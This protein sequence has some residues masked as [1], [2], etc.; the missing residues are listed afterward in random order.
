MKKKRYNRLVAVVLLIVTVISLLGGAGVFA[1]EVLENP[2]Q[3]ESKDTP[4]DDID[5]TQDSEDSNTSNQEETSPQETNN[6]DIKEEGQ[7]ENK[8]EDTTVSSTPE[9]EEPEE[10]E[11]PKDE[12]K[13]EESSS[14]EYSL[15]LSV[16]SE[17]GGS[18]YVVLN[19]KREFATHGV[20]LNLPV[21]NGEEV[22]I[23][24]INHTGYCVD[25][26]K[27][28]I[29]KS[30]ISENIMAPS[31]TGVSCELLY[32]VTGNDHLSFSFREGTKSYGAPISEKKSKVRSA[33]STAELSWLVSS[34]TTGCEIKCA[35]DQN[36][37][38][39]S[40]GEGVLGAGGTEALCM[41]YAVNFKSGTGT[42]RDAVGF[43]GLSEND[44]RRIAVSLQGAE[45]YMA[46]HPPSGSYRRYYIKQV[47]VWRILSEILGWGIN[48]THLLN[49]YCPT[50]YQ[51]AVL[52]AAWQF[53]TD[54][55]SEYI[56]RGTVW[57]NGNGQPVARFWTEPATGKLKILK[58]SFE[59]SL[60]EGNPCYSLENAVLGIYSDRGCTN[61]I[62]RLTTR[63]DGTT[64]SLDLTQGTYYV[65][66]LSTPKGFSLISYE[67]DTPEVKAVT[68]ESGKTAEVEF[69]NYPVNDPVNIFLFKKDLDFDYQQQSVI[70]SSQGDANLEGAIFK[71]DYYASQSI[72]KEQIWGGATP[73]MSFLFTSVKIHL[74]DNKYVYTVNLRLPECYLGSPSGH[75]LPKYDGIVT[76]PLGTLAITEMSPPEGYHIEGS[77]ILDPN[78]DSQISDNLVT[79][80]ITGNGD[81]ASS[82]SVMQAVDN[83]NDVNR[84]SLVVYKRDYETGLTT[85]SGSASLDGAVFSLKNVSKNP[86]KYGGKTI[87]VGQEVTRETTYFDSS[88]NA[89]VAV[90]DD[91]P[92]GTYEVTE[93]TPPTGYTLSGSSKVTASIRDH[94]EVVVLTGDPNECIRNE[95]IKGGVKIQKRDHETTLAEAREDTSLEGAK[96]N[97]IS[98]SARPVYIDG[99]YYSRGEVVTTLT[100]NAQGIAQTPYNF[101]PYG[102]YEI[103]EIES[104]CGFLNEGKI[105]TRFNVEDDHLIVNMTYVSKAISNLPIRGDLEFLKVAGKPEGEEKDELDP[106]K[107]ARFEIVSKK[108]G[109]VKMT[110]ES[111]E[112][113]IVSTVGR[114][115][116]RGALVYGTYIVREIYAPPGYEKIE[117]FEFQI[118]EEGVTVQYIY[119]EDKLIETPI[120][121]VKKDKSTGKV[122]PLANTTF[123]LLDSNK[124]VMS[125]EQFYPNHTVLNKFKT[126]ETGSFTLPEKLM[127]G[128]YYFREVQAPNGYLRG[129]DLEFTVEEGRKWNNPLILE[130]SDDN[131]M[132]KLRLVKKDFDTNSALAG[133]SFQIT[134]K[135]NIV[136]N[137]GTVRYR[138]GDVVDNITTNAQGI[139]ESKLLYIGEYNLQ[140]R[141]TPDGYTLDDTVKSFSIR[142]VNQD[143]PVYVHNMELKNKP[144]E[145]K[146]FK[147]DI[148]NVKLQGITFSITNLT[149]NETVSRTTD[150]NGEI[151]IKYVKRGSYKVVETATLPGYVLDTAPRFFSVSQEGYIK[152]TNNQG[153]PVS[154]SANKSNYLGLDWI[155]DYTKVDFSKFEITGTEEISG[156][157]LQVIN[158]QG[159][160]VYEWETGSVPHRIVKIPVGSYTLHEAVTPTG[161][162]TA[163]DVSFTVQSTGNVQRFSMRDKQVFATKVDVNDK[164]L[165]GATLTVTDAQG[166]IKDTW[167]TGTE[168]HAI[169]GL[170]VGQTYTLR[171]TAAPTGYVTALPVTFTVEDN[172]ENQTIKM[173]DKRV[174]VKK[175]DT[176]GNL[177]VGAKM[178]VTDRAGIVIDEWTTTDKEHYVSGLVVGES[179]ILKEVQPPKGYVK[180]SN[181]EF[182]VTE[183]NENQHYVMVDKQVKVSKTDV[184]GEE[185]LEGALLKVINAN[186]ETVDEWTSSKKQH[187]IDG[188]EVNNSYTL[189]EITAPEGYVKSSSID[190]YVP[191]DGK[192]QAVHMVDKQL[193]V[194]KKEITGDKEL[195][196]ATLTVRDENDE[197]VDEW[198]SSDKPH[199]VSN[200]EV[201][202][203]YTLTETITPDEYVKASTITFEVKDD[204]KN[205]FVTMVDKQVEVSKTDVTGEKELEGAKLTVKDSDNKVVD[206]WISGKKPHFVSGLE[207]NKEYTLT[208]TTTPNGYVTASSIKFSVPEDNKIQKVHMIDKRVEVSK[209]DVTGE[210][211][212]PGATLTVKDS[213]DKVVDE[214]I[215]TEETHFI[216]GLKVGNK[217]TLTEILAPEGYV[218]ASTI[219]F[220][221][222]EDGKD[223][224]IHM[225]DKQVF[226]TKT[227]ITGDEEVIGAHLIVKDKEGNIVDEWISGE[228]PHPVSG[229][230]VDRE[231]ILIEEQAPDGYVIAEEIEFNVEDDGTIQ[232]V[233]MHDKQVFINKS[234]LIKEDEDLSK[235]VVPNTEEDEDTSDDIIE[236]DKEDENTSEDTNDASG[237]TSDMETDKEEDEK[238]DTKKPFENKDTKYVKFSKY[239]FKGFVDKIIDF[240]TP[241][242]EEEKEPPMVDSGE[243]IIE[244][245]ASPKTDKEDS[246]E[247][248]KEESEDSNVLWA[249]HPKVKNGKF[250]TDE[251]LTGRRYLVGTKL[252]VQDLKGNVVDE[253][254]TDG[255]TY[256]VSNL[257]I[258]ETYNLVEVEATKGYVKSV[259][260]QFTV[261]KNDENQFILM[262]D[263]QVVLYKKDMAG[264]E[265]PGAS[266]TITNEEGEVVDK[267]ISSDNPHAI[268]NLEEGKKYKF[269]EESSP[270]GYI[271]VEEFEFIVDESLTNLHIQVTDDHTRTEISKQDATTGK[272]LAGA[273]LTLFDSDGK[274]IESWTSSN[275]PHKI[276]RLKP[277]TYRLHEDLAPIGYKTAS[278]VT[279]EVKAV[280]EVLKVVMKDEVQPKVTMVQTGENIVI[281]IL[282]GILLIALLYF[283]IRRKR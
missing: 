277:G 80:R 21:Q 68:V 162:V 279:F 73:Q 43:Y 245:V 105:T 173:V 153:V 274:K 130:Y 30:D 159:R 244:K 84:G 205:Q 257:V 77:I 110:V 157:T 144:T 207:V 85:P 227:D 165:S 238:E 100:T 127:Y 142:Y 104:P 29:L 34:S 113:G 156:A 48:N 41:N 16:D 275:E 216:S 133:A 67:G 184:T 188:L 114:G 10:E 229:L 76:F 69:M 118:R 255:N 160:V 79:I 70:G 86:I 148:D 141:S 42:A 122:I 26:V 129:Q 259:P 252:Q 197:V 47:I 269:K 6:E 203:T 117:P 231:Y 199:Y 258:G 82:V 158:D 251:K 192:I 131:A 124:N 115:N 15:S 171:E 214:W 206:E 270:D 260:Y 58:K 194:S 126:D 232:Y 81:I 172:L 146:L 28:E 120:K 50:A 152:Q 66:E 261:E 283:I 243:G 248:E 65:K 181:I 9:Q 147:K 154:G 195:P 46:A 119:Q 49:E 13:Q 174:D 72:T 99:K 11:T 196:G 218:K 91:L 247:P 132:G 18:V 19:N 166:N 75:Q 103:R 256:A 61:E 191:E 273:Q 241:D 180:A 150:A 64:D 267:W 219:E 190:F 106:L 38:I 90:F 233:E 112:N 215:S 123:E 264:E 253:W 237:D 164:T 121:L 210:K 135:E 235:P 25:L 281:F 221:V 189:V 109:Q 87:G 222:P 167:Q 97:I 107:G 223:Q 59:P 268:E 54:H 24:I 211:E 37:I 137:D 228:E 236:S 14:G 1:D 101:L 161:Y 44:V 33:R 209:T 23:G 52:N 220:E 63:A 186:G 57:E 224:K 116:Q 250:T 51:G 280:P 62:G 185:E 2:V 125:L 32:K 83:N 20:P 177:L 36:Q 182:T 71:L 108:T 163:N 169:S 266:I 40:W 17:V 22:L 198:V 276:E 226:V 95:V 262:K 55:E 217:Y 271:V 178:A 193:S 200:L 168:P 183:A 263:K 96:F 5:S 128:T 143:T 204:G 45:N 12:P 155:N 175:K 94:N 60:S 3:V 202:K 53:C 8:S 140:E 138:K 240:F 89:S 254:V 176:E 31:D 56:G 35:N 213:K 230:E 265:L 136:T 212:L 170:H 187:F 7:E 225:V 278:D 208:E 246:K 98:L 74:E 239:P 27:S 139:A 111:D 242:S 179:Y 78:T 92:Y 145:F 249:E 88:Y 234:D 282:V 4:T 149:T 272:E 102:L 134:A 201:G 39:S 151:D 93:V